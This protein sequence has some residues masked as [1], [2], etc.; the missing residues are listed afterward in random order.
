MT[1]RFRLQRCNWAA[2]SL[3]IL[4]LV[5][6]PGLVSAEPSPIHRDTMEPFLKKYC[7][8][9]HGEKKQKGHTRFDTISW[10]I[11]SN[12]DAQDWQDVLDVLNSGDMPPEDEAQP[13]ESEFS[14]VVGLLTNDL[15]IA[16]DRLAATGGENPIRRLNKREYLSTI[17]QLFG[18][19]VDESFIPDDIRSEHFDTAG[20]EQYFDGPLL[21]HYIKIGTAIAKEGFKYSG[22]PYEEVSTKRYEAEDI[23]KGKE[24]RD[25][26][27]PK[28][29]SGAYLFRGDR[30]WRQLNIPNGSDPRASYR[31]RVR[32]GTA[33]PDWPMRH[34]LVFSEASGT[35]G[36]DP[37]TLGVL[38]VPGSVDD[39]S[40]T[41]T[42]VKRT[43][44]DLLGKPIIEVTE[45]APRGM[46]NITRWF[47]IYVSMMGADK[48]KP[49]IWVDWLELE[50]PHYES[51][52]NI[53]GTLIDPE[54][55]DL[56]R[57]N[58]AREL[59][60]K[61]AYEA[62][63]R[64]RPNRQ[65]IDKLV[66][67]FEDRLDAGLPYSDA[68]SETIGL[69]LASPGFLY[70]EANPENRSKHLTD[71]DFANRLSYFLWSSPPDEEL[72]ELAK[73]GRLS[74]PMEVRKQVDRMLADDRAEQFYN[75][76]MSQWA[77]LDR[78]EDISVDWREFISFNEATFFSAHREPVEFFKVLV[79]DN[80]GVNNLI[81]SDFV[82]INP[83]LEQFY[84]I[85]EKSVENEFKKV[86][87]AP[88]DPRGGFITQSAF[89]TAGSNGTR[90]SPVIRGT[91]ILDKIL[92]NPPPQPPPNV[93]EIE[94]ASDKPLTNREL[95]EMHTKQKV[96]ASCHDKID[97]IGFGLENF[98]TV[99]LWRDTE[100][101][102]EKE[103]PI[104][105]SGTLVSGTHFDDLQTLQK[106]LKSQGHQ[107]G[108]NMIESLTAYAIGRPIEFSDKENI[109]DIL[110]FAHK[111]GFAMRD[112]IFLV[113]N[114]ET[115]RSK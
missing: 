24:P 42:T 73:S 77:E 57:E 28:L 46:T 33:D 61:F 8:K 62:F 51:E 58:K 14:Q 80:L 50:G 54:G 94:S 21:D 106:L 39:P 67:Y 34:Y 37:E 100:L 3:K 18:L 86:P 43:T 105:S 109:D 29:D 59:L 114:S 111:R 93:P 13:R 82:V 7:M 66:A 31:I 81:D 30:A 97:P 48:E 26:S 11:T 107:L 89:L 49:N 47:P 88:D 40:I 103:V 25:L 68:M 78:F 101:V 4:L 95:T 102:D 92:N 71:E 36:A 15:S 83:A 64:V 32:A 45:T 72:Y 110:I 5:L 12:T 74:D 108:R 115:F 90:S 76:F 44:L 79:R 87:I 104:D 52:S 17:K 20:S 6:V 16:R 55:E 10:L 41:E 60:E 84:N 27:F 9:C 1:S 56:A 91:I 113:A 65:Y 70:L 38:N 23:T 2:S 98:D 53:F 22:R 85:P 69:V 112:L 19:N 99:G 75:G 35:R 63:R 96:C